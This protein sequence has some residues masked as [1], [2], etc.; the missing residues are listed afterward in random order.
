[1]VFMLTSGLLC[2]STLTFSTQRTCNLASAWLLLTPETNHWR[3]VV[4]G[5]ARKFGAAVNRDIYFAIANDQEHR[6]ELEV[7]P[8][9]SRGCSSMR[10][11][12]SLGCWV[13]SWLL[14]YACGYISGLLGGS[15]QDLGLWGTDRELVVAILDADRRF[16][17]NDDFSAEAL[18]EFV[19]VSPTVIPTLTLR[20]FV[21]AP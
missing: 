1:M 13:I 21:R 14:S 6:S 17:L 8:V 7:I 10:V 3:D 18:T 19:E 2:V 5:V 15:L 11:D 12:K 20:T 16:V 9:S 4:A